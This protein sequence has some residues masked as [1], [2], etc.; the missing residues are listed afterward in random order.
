MHAFTANYICVHFI[1]L[2][3]SMFFFTFLLFLLL[4]YASP[5]FTFSLYALFCPTLYLCTYLIHLSSR[6]SFISPSV[7]SFILPAFTV[8]LTLPVIFILAFFPLLSSCISQPHSPFRLVAHSPHPQFYPP[9][10]S[11]S[12]SYFLHSSVLRRI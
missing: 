7:V 12:H 8:Y 3:S 5:S 11:H 4:C 2:N 1:H 9:A 10:P 6:G